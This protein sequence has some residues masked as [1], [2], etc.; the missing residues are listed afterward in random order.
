MTVANDEAELKAEAKM[1]RKT[2]KRRNSSATR[3]QARRQIAR[4][5]L[6]DPGSPPCATALYDSTKPHD[7]PVFLRGEAGQQRRH[8]PAALFGDSLR[9]QPRA[10]PATAAAAWNWPTRSST[11]T[12]R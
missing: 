8:R 5:E 11:R 1:M 6:T 2:P 12:I 7:S 10:L 3:H 4:L 9:P